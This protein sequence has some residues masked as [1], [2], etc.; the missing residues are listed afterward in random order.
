MLVLLSSGK[1]KRIVSLA[2]GRTP[3]AFLTI[4]DD[5]CP[6]RPPARDVCVC[7]WGVGGGGG[8]AEGLRMP[9]YSKSS[10]TQT[11][12]THVPWPIRSHYVVRFYYSRLVEASLMSTFNKPLYHR[13]QKKDLSIIPI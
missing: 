8:G 12:M 10:M 3:Q 6:L 13:R 5:K 4:S 1:W 9:E 11:P 2:P 7:V